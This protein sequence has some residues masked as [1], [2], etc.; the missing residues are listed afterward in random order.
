[1]ETSPHEKR[2]DSGTSE[3]RSDGQA[4]FAQTQSEDHQEVLEAVMAEYLEK[5][6]TGKSPDPATYLEAYPQHADELSTFFRNH[7]WLGTSSTPETPS[8]LGSS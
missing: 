7:H 3:D 2:N 8:L 6:E 4:D 5:I 1:M